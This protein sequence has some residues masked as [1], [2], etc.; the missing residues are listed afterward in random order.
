V[1]VLAQRVLMAELV[2]GDLVLTST[3]AGKT[4]I[5]RVLVNQHAA[6]D[7]HTSVLTLHTPSGR[8]SVTPDHVLLADD[9]FVAAWHVAVGMHLV[10]AEGQPLVV[11]Q[12]TLQKSATVINPI[13]TAG[14][15]LA[16]D[17]GTPVLA[18]THPEWVA[19]TMLDGVGAW[20]LPLSMSHA[21]SYAFPAAAQAYYDDAL[22]PIFTELAPSMAHGM[23]ALPPALVVTVAVL[24]D[25]A[26]AAGFA[27]WGLGCVALTLGAV[28]LLRPETRCGLG[29][30]VHKPLLRM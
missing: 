18:A 7:A 19:H 28:V 11:R 5:T 6:T 4:A 24:G 10:G 3:P 29:F 14:T 12:I 17:V 8:V 9:A 1:P 2:A 23:A 20:L 15:I 13:T 25:S 21:L 16:I 26:L 27:F 30:T 22:E